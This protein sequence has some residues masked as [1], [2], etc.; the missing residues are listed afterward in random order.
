MSSARIDFPHAGVRAYVDQG[1]NWSTQAMAGAPV[2]VMRRRRQ[3]AE[4]L[5]E[6]LNA[7]YGPGGLWMEDHHYIADKVEMVVRHVVDETGGELGAYNHD[8]PTVPDGHVA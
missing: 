7:R 3:A 6:M 2:R 1:L 8:P 4:S 5:R